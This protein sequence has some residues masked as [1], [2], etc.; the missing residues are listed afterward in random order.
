[1]SA[2]MVELVALMITISLCAQQV[3]ALGNK[4]AMYLGF[5]KGN[6]NRVIASLYRKLA[7]DGVDC[8]FIIVKENKEEEELAVG[9][10]L[11]ERRY[12]YSEVAAM[13]N[14]T[15]CII[16]VL[17]DGQKTQSFRYFEAITYNKKLLTN[18]PNISTLPYYDSRYMKYF[19]NVDEVDSAWVKK[20]EEINY[21]YQGEFSQINLLN[22]IEKYFSLS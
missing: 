2:R 10:S 18:N 4:L 11:T 15:N 8:N 6:R 12:S 21:G 19:S 7:N 20:K 3:A 16:E 14:S 1:M 17:M 13:A 22:I 5:N 9:L